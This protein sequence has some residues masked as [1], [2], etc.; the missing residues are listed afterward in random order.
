MRGSIARARGW[1]Y[2]Y[3]MRERGR[4]RERERQGET[5]Q[6]LMPCFMEAITVPPNPTL[7]L[8]GFWG[9]HGVDALRWSFLPVKLSDLPEQTSSVTE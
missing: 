8:E 1:D 4:E 3:H 2:R 5:C 6:N 7:K 9:L